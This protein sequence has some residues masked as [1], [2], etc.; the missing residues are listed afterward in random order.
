[1]NQA[2]GQTQ[3]DMPQHPAPPQNQYTSPPPTGGAYGGYQPP[4]AQ[5]QYGQPNA[6]YGQAPPQ[7]Q[8]GSG[9][10]GD[11]SRGQANS[12]YDSYG[13][14]MPSVPPQGQHDTRANQ[15]YGDVE[16]KDKKKDEKKSSGYGGAIGGA[17]A[18]LAVGGI[19]GA[20]IANALDDSDDEKP[21]AAA[22][23]APSYA[24]APTNYA[25]VPD[26]SYGG[27]GATSQDSYGYNASA[28]VAQPSGYGGS[29]YEPGLYDDAPLPDETRSGSSVS[30]SD[31]ESLEE[32]RE[33]LREAQEE[34]EEEYAETYDD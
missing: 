9:P 17:A 19:G 33:E 16:N 8:Y 20:L 26:P 3:W 28:P 10:Q 7:G 6:P 11:Q 21:H 18:G 1:M 27:Y 29:A 32:K 23:A 4:H 14:A 12:F 34:Y 25:P 31:R 15:Y 22:A 2:T 24:P 13:G 5:G 30:S